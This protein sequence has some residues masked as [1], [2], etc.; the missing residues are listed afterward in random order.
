MWMKS[1]ISSATMMPLY[2]LPVAWARSFFLNGIL[3]KGLPGGKHQI[4]GRRR[5]ARHLVR[6]MRRMRHL[7]RSSLWRPLPYCT[8]FKEPLERALR[9]SSDGKCE[10]SKDVDCIWDIIVRKMTE[11]GR[12]D[13]LLEFKPPKSWTT[14]RDGGPRR[15]IREELVK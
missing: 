3:C 10:I 14:A 6:E 7:R 5:R 12:L 9:R 13:E 1:R 4:H 2:P 15:M 11:Q 8:L